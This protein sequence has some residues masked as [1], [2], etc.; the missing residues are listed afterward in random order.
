M[1]T[2]KLDLSLRLRHPAEALDAIAQRLGLT[3]A[4]NWVKGNPRLSLKGEP[5]SGTRESSYCSIPLGATGS[6]ELDE[7]LTAC[8]SRIESIKHELVDLVKSGGTASI[9]IGWFCDG[10]AGD[11]VSSQTVMRLS[12]LRLKLDFYLYFSTGN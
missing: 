1:G 12:R 11:S 4:V 6:V 7:A 9:A 3:P 5:L 2:K 8:L 10:D